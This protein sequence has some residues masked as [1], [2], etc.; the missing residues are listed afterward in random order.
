MALLFAGA[1]VYFRALGLPRSSEK[2]F[3]RKTGCFRRYGGILHGGERLLGETY[4]VGIL[5]NK[6]SRVVV[7]IL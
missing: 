5:A 2:L 6:E 3:E 4:D 1:E 7:V